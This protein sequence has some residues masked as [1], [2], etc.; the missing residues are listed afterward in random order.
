MGAKATETVALA[1]ARHPTFSRLIMP[2]DTMSH[3]AFTPDSGL[4]I[5]YP[6][7]KAHKTISE[8]RELKLQLI[9]SIGQANS[10]RWV[11]EFW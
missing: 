4:T 6:E 11:W 10:I 2:P 5:H 7:T 8:I 1:Q 9:A 3:R